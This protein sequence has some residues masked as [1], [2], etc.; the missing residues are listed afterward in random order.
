[1]RRT[2][3]YLE[4]ELELLLER[5]TKRRGQPMAAIIRDAVRAFLTRDEISGPP[6]AG[7]FS[8]QRPDTA[9]DADRALAE[10]GFAKQDS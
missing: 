3:I 10:T 1:M 2:T 4:P 7:A 6:G 5:E 8:S 9:S